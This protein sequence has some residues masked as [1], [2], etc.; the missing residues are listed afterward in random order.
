MHHGF[1]AGGVTVRMEL[2]DDVTDGARRLLV[3][4]CGEQPK[5]A[6]CVDDPALDRLQ[7]VPDVGQRPVE[8]DVHRVVEIG[9]FRKE[10]HRDL[11]DGMELEPALQNGWGAV[12]ASGLG[13]W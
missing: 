4:A 3:L 5:F 11:L 12:L 1:V 13:R 7:S 6:H 9:L 8:N 10:P 2:A